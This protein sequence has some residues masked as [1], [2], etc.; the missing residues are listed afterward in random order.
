MESNR[1][2]FIDDFQD[3]AHSKRAVLVGLV[4]ILIYHLLAVTA[5]S[6]VFEKWPLIDSIY[7]GVVCFTTVGFGDLVPHTDLGKLFVIFFA[8]YG[9]LILGF[10]VSVIGELVIEMQDRA[11]KS[12]R[13]TASRHVLRMFSSGDEMSERVEEEEA[14]EI[15]SKNQ[16]KSLVVELLRVLM[17][18]APILAIISLIAILIGFS[19]GWS[20]IKSLYFCVITSTTIGFGDLHPDKTSLKVLSIL[21]LPFAVAVF[22]ECLGRV[23]GVFFDRANRQSEK[24][25]LARQLTLS[26][27]KTMDVDADGKVSMG[28]FLGYMLVAMQKVDKE[29]MVE[30]QQLFHKLDTNNNGSL[31]KADLVMLTKIR[32]EKMAAKHAAMLASVGRGTV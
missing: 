26:D 27:L 19:E 28:E 22:G 14:E 1:R 29:D 2:R 3:F 4:N 21:F 18:E 9:I 15:E 11:I 30:L 25:F 16:Q 20:I 13:R 23:A 8:V 12:A 17:L 5:F 10:F 31:D 24:E 6:F 7:F 32:R